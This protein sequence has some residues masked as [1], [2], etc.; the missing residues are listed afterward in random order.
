MGRKSDFN[1]SLSRAEAGEQENRI[2]YLQSTEE[3][4]RG[5]LP[6]FLPNHCCEVSTR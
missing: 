6:Y 2:P 4:V 3:R 5:I 1:L